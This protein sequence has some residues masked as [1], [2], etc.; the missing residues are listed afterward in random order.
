M[1]ERIADTE[2]K[3]FLLRMAQA[4]SKLAE[5]V[6]KSAKGEPADASSANQSDPEQT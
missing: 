1:A 5:Q 2:R 3:V 6:E 4:W